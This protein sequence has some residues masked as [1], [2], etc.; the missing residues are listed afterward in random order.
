MF[1]SVEIAQQLAAAGI[2]TYPFSDESDLNAHK[3]SELLVKRIVLTDQLAECNDDISALANIKPQPKFK[4]SINTKPQ[5]EF[6]L[7][8]KYPNGVQLF[9][10]DVF[11]FNGVLYKVAVGN[12]YSELSQ[13]WG[14]V[15]PTSGGV[16]LETHTGDLTNVYHA[17]HETDDGKPLN[18]EINPQSSET[19]NAFNG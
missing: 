4:L 5:P 8:N 17:S 13:R 16:T 7:R 9:S 18:T 15:L 10:G 14:A 6:K 19:E 3:L 2:S 12:K 1:V 11:R